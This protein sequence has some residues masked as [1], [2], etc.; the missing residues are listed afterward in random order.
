MPPSA[1]SG[2]KGVARVKVH[3]MLPDSAEE[4]PTDEEREMFVE[5]QGKIKFLNVKDPGAFV[6]R[7]LTKTEYGNTLRDLLEVDPAIAGGLPDG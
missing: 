5:W 2:K 3:D 7:R 6:I 1:S 4:Q